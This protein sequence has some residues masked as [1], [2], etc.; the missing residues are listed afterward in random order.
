MERW[1]TLFLLFFWFFNFSLAQNPQ[2]NSSG[3]GTAYSTIPGF[4]D[5]QLRQRLS[6]LTNAIV[7]PRLNRIVKSYINTYTL[8]KR[9]KT[10]TMLGKVEM[11]FPLFEKYLEQHRLPTDLKFLPILESALNPNA[12]SRS[13]AVGLWQFMPATGRE[14][15]LRINS[16]VD[17]RRDPNKSTLAAIKYLTR[18]YKKYGDWSLALAA[19]NGGPGRVNR[20]IKRARS[21]NFWRISKYLPRETRAYVPGFIA[22]YYIVHFYEQHNLMPAYPQV[23][24]QITE[25]TTIY[26]RISFQKISEITGTPIHQIQALN[27]SYKRLFIPSSTKGNYLVLPQHRMADMLN[28]LGRPDQRIKHLA[29]GHIAAPNAYTIPSDNFKRSVYLAQGTEQL[30]SLARQF[31]CTVDDIKQWNRLR[32]EKLQRGQ[33]IYFYTPKISAI[34]L[35][36]VPLPAADIQAQSS[37]IRVLPPRIYTTSKIRAVSKK[38]HFSK[39]QK[40]SKYIYYQMKRRES[41]Q[42]VVRRFPGNSLQELIEINNINKNRISQLKPGTRILVRVPK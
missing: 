29:A 42:D 20:A 31:N 41:L 12:V 11:Y 33:S 4:T 25:T 15:G 37:Q 16:L 18:L 22:A 7:A 13:G 19:Y 3:F 38:Y 21:K 2:L 24:L 9:D 39:E 35:L 23:D 27:P 36:P 26:E 5:N 34:D 28:H 1:I 17:E 40:Q 32:S 14:N 30:K 6:S 8:K 10:E